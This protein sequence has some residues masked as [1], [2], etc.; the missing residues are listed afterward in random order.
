[1]TEGPCF[2]RAS[3]AFVHDSPVVGDSSNSDEMDSFHALSS[4]MSLNSERKPAEVLRIDDR[5]FCF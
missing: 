3:A 1:M 5:E 2:E 4:L